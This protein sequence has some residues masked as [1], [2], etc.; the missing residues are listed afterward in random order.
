MAKDDYIMFRCTTEY[1]E[2]VQ[3]KAEAFG[4]S[5]TSEFLRFLVANAEK[6]FQPS[7]SGDNKHNSTSVLDSQG[8]D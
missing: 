7:S 6:I 2:E 8:S 4:F 5:N 1:K 3:R